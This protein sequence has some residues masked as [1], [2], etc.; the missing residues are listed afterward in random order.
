VKKT[1]GA[2][3]QIQ[4]EC[5]TGPSQFRFVFISGENKMAKA[6][7]S[8]TGK[9]KS[10]AATKEKPK[11]KKAKVDPV[12]KGCN[13]VSVYLVVPNSDEAL[14]FYTAAFGAKEAMRMMGPDGK[15]VMH[16]SMRLGDSTIML[17]DEN[18][19]WG[20]KSP[21]TL[22]GTPVS[23]HLYVKDADKLFERAVAAGCT[24]IMPI[25]DQ[26]WGDRFGRLKDP[27]GHEWSI[28][29]QKEILSKKEL[30]KRQQAFFAQMAT[31]SPMPQ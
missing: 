17:A 28:G 27:F 16:A 25:G 13:T 1:V 10:S 3:D 15:S 22:S 8:A 20:S 24:V 19:Q 11:P 31:S 6:T 14:K 23:I 26:F 7:A 4:L 2:I 12:P 18:P 21:A 9:S 30:L 29:T 5:L